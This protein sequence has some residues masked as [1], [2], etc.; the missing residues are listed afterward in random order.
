MAVHFDHAGV[1]CLNRTQLRVVAD[2]RDRS[3]GT[4]D[5]IDEELIGLGFMLNSVNRYVKHEVLPLSP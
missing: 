2:V 3:A 1:A 5:Q 4:V